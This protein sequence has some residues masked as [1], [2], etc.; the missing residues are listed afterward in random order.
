MLAFLLLPAPRSAQV[1]PSVQ[2]KA[3]ASYTTDSA[4]PQVRG[5]YSPQ[6]QLITLKVDRFPIGARLC[7]EATVLASNA[8]RA[9][10]TT[11]MLTFWSMASERQYKEHHHVRIWVDGK[12]VLDDEAWWYPSRVAG[13]QELLVSNLLGDQFS[14]LANASSVKIEVGGTKIVLTP[15]AVAVLK[16]LVRRTAPSAAP[17]ALDT[18]G[19]GGIS[20]D[21]SRIAA[22]TDAELVALLSHE[23]LARNISLGHGMVDLRAG[24]P[25]PAQQPSARGSDS[26][27]GVVQLSITPAASLPYPEAVV[28]ELVR[29]H[30]SSELL[31]AF[32]TTID[33]IQLSWLLQTLGRI[34][35]AA[36]DSALAAIA[37]APDTLDPRTIE[38]RTYFALKYFAEVGTPWALRILNCNYDRWPVSSMERADIVS[39]F[40]T[41]KYYPSTPNLAATIDAALVNLGDAALTGLEVMFPEGRKDFRGPEEATTYWKR[42]VSQ[43]WHGPRDD[44]RRC[45]SSAP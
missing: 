11:V 28:E 10:I 22:Y 36:V 40:G 20:Y 8:P 14:T 16:D 43:H 29:R 18:L 39:L 41:Y 35:G 17:M 1:P 5:T 42:Y 37:T 23:S 44:E 25:Q 34:R 45:R 13:Y 32:D 21:S 15:T 19:P 26:S 7:L 38:E 6:H 31:Q 30:A 33:M 3:C 24:N 12:A 4:P 9:H 27:P 2:Q